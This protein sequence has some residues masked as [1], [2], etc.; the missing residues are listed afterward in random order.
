MY[1]NVFFSDEIENSLA[2]LNN[3]NEIC[4][5]ITLNK[6]DYYEEESVDEVVKQTIEDIIVS[7][8][9]SNSFGVGF[10]K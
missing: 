7:L 3:E 6:N 10:L 9:S 4:L 5:G 1:S 2:E 8:D